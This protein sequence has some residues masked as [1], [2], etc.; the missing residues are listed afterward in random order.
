MFLFNVYSNHDKTSISDFKHNYNVISR[1]SEKK[2][3]KIF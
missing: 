2:A 3:K 1:N